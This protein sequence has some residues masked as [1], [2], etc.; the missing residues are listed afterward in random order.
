[1]Q[2][3]SMYATIVAFKEATRLHKTIMQID[4]II[5]MAKDHILKHGR[6]LTEIIVELDT[7]EMHIMGCPDITNSDESLEKQH[8]FFTAGR[9]LGEEN[10]GKSIAH[11]AFTVEAWVG[12]QKL[13]Q[14]PPGYR[15]SKD[16]NRKECLIVMTLDIVTK[17]ADEHIEQ[18]CHMFEMIRDGSGK[19]I[20]LVASGLEG[21]KAQSKLLTAFLAGFSSTQ[22]T[23]EQRDNILAKTM[24]PDATG[25][26]VRK[27]S[28]RIFERKMYMADV[29]PS[30]IPHKRSATSYRKAKK[31]RR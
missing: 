16:P 24:G 1:M 28:K 26:E 19:L 29:T 7:Q 10:P 3:S 17:E 22:M 2:D 8:R 11:I 31:K 25:E 21:V 14:V 23:K 13:G 12:Q 30:N 27:A 20:D 5:Q 15:P 4:K 9:M 6:H 18:Y